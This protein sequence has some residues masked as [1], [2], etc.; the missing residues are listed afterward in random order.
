VNRNGEIFDSAAS[1]PQDKVWLEH[2]KQMLAESLTN[3]RNAANGLLTALGLLEGIYL[4]MLGFAQFIPEESTVILQMLFFM[5]L[6]LWLA[7]VYFC[8]GVLMTQKLEV[9]L[10]SPT[11]IREQTTRQLLKKQFLMKMAFWLLALGLLAAFGLLI[12]RLQR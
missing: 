9:N 5:P 12:A 4:G 11:D 7:S 2:G 1:D 8:V 6:L 3:V 10:N